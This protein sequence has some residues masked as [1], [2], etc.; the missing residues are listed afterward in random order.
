MRKI[1][2]RINYNYSFDQRGSHGSFYLGVVVG[3]AETARFL[4]DM[5]THP[6]D[7]SH[8]EITQSV[9]ESY[10]MRFSRIKL[11]H[12]HFQ[13]KTSFRYIY[14]CI[15]YLFFFG[16]VVLNFLGEEKKFFSFFV[17]IFSSPSGMNGEQAASYHCNND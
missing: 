6:C 9:V 14:I 2:A 10:R 4:P 8:N 7:C 16:C 12:F 1:R 17:S 11:S 13:R 3:A 5:Q 15:I